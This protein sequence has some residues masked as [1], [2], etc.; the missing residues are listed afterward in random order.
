MILETNN[1]FLK[2]D[3][4]TFLT[5]ILTLFS[6]YI[7]V[8]RLVELLFLFFSGTSVSYWGPIKYTFALA[9]PVFAFL[10]SG[11][12]SFC[13][14]RK[15]KLSF[16]YLYCISLYIIGISMIIQWSN[17]ILWL[18]FTSVPNY[19]GIVTEFSELVKPAFTSLALYLP[20]VTVPMLFKFT[21]VGVN[22]TLL[23]IESIYDYGGINLKEISPKF[24]KSKLYSNLYF[25]GE[26]MDI[27]ALT[28]GFNIQLAFSTA[29][30]CASDFKN[31]KD[32]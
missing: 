14:S 8:D 15:I 13:T 23:Q 2:T 31:L 32:N 7:A 1:Y 12:S 27:D 21:Y 3:K 26:V 4:N 6:I 16:F 20:I 28:G 11:A 19:V 22:D 30:A 25:V 18:L 10:F 29:V 9:C 17:L 24:M 5:Y